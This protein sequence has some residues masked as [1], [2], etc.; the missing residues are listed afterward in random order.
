MPT[1]IM[2]S[3]SQEETAAGDA[4]AARPILDRVWQAAE[5]IETA[6]LAERVASLEQRLAG[7]GK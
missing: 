6:D 2:C 5:A 3:P 1:E 4:L 7:A